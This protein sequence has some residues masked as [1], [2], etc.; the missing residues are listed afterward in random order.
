MKKLSHKKTKLFLAT[1]VAVSLSFCVLSV[2]PAMACCSCGCL[3]P[4]FDNL[5][6]QTRDNINNHTDDE[7]DK[8]EDWMINTWWFKKMRPMMQQMTDELVSAQFMELEMVGMFFDAENQLKTQRLLQEKMA[9]ANKDYIPS[10]NVCKMGSLTRSVAHG[11]GRSL[12][13]QK[14]LAK[15][16]IDRHLHTIN[17]ISAD[18]ANADM[19]SR[20][21]KFKTIYCDKDDFN[22]AFK[23]FCNRATIGTRVNKDVDYARTVGAELSLSVD[24]TDP[25]LSLYEEDIIALE[26]N[27]YGHDP[28]TMFTKGQLESNATHDEYLDLRSVAAKRSV[29]ENSFNALV[30]MKTGGAALSASLPNVNSKETNPQYLTTRLLEELGMPE[31]ETKRYL[32]EFPSYHAQ[33]EILTKKLYQDPAFITNLYD[34][35]A[36][37]KRQMAAMQSFGLMQQRDIYDSLLRTEML[38]SVLLE[39]EIVDEQKEVQNEVNKLGRP[40]TKRPM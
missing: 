35:P 39:L 40:G 17:T 10:E 28:L 23:L 14:A 38:L 4:D 27:L 7:F 19:G 8:H 13:T 11:E 12:V 36:N 33:M 31:D 34:T 24:F 25:G 21:K 1:F 9:A 5:H 26:R 15:G 29:A 37:V 32:S 3:C 2:T 30:G 16:A 20:L 18:N 22:G 6:D